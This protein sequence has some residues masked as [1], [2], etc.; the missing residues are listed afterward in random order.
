MAFILINF[1]PFP[2]IR[3]CGFFCAQSES[4]LENLNQTGQYRSQRKKNFKERA[5]IILPFPQKAKNVFQL[6]K[7]K[8]TFLSLQTK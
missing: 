7:I 1:F 2:I 3:L 4:S 5:T 8:E 6:G